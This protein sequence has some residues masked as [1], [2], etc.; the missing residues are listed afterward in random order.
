MPAP[1]RVALPAGMTVGSQYLPALGTATA[2]ALPGGW[3]LRLHDG[4]DGDAPPTHLELDLAAAPPRL[5]VHGPAGSW[6]HALTPRHAEIMLS[7]VVNGHGRS[8][9]ELAGDLFADP[10]RAITVRAEMARLRRVLG[11]VLGRQPYR[12]DE[13]IRTRLLLPASRQA[14]LP[15]SSAPVSAALRDQ[16]RHRTRSG[17]RL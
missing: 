15:G 8:A 7:L 13:H 3:L 6:T 5:Q 17:G 2:E 10:S 16:R 12:I 1:E 4:D 9:A 11:P 14:I